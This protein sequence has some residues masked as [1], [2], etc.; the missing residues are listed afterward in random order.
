MKS[1][2]H[3]TGDIFSGTMIICKFEVFICENNWK[4]SPSI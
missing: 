2:P 4:L 3:R 1:A